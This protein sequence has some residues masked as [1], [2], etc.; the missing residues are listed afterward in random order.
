MNGESWFGPER[1]ANLKAI[2]L[3]SVFAVL[4]GFA[5]WRFIPT[6]EVAEGEL[7]SYAA[8]LLVWPALVLLLMVA[9]CFRTFDVVGAFDPLSGAES[10]RFRINARVLQNS[11]E[12]SLIFTLALLA[13]AASS[14]V[15]HARLLLA[16]CVAFC[17]GRLLFWVGY[18]VGLQQRGY[19][20]SLGFCANLGALLMALWFA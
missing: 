19:G 17:L 6:P 12:Q 9:S 1:I 18:H 2:S 15:V 20:F 11:V 3:S 7:L 13:A 8:G 4:V 10:R 5:L 16:L 14:P